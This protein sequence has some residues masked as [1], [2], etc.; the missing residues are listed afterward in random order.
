MNIRYVFGITFPARSFATQKRTWWP[1]GPGQPPVRSG[2]WLFCVGSLD[3]LKSILKPNA[4]VGENEAVA[5]AVVEPLACGRRLWQSFPDETVAVLLV[6]LPRLNQ[7][8][9]AVLK[10]LWSD[11][12]CRTDTGCVVLA[13]T[14]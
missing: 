1:H 10:Q 14:Q 7:R 8:S 2:V 4:A 11:A 13:R 12:S 9:V 6:V 5:P 3:S